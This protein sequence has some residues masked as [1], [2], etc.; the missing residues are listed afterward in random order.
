MTEKHRFRQISQIWT[1][2]IFMR[3][4]AV[5]SKRGVQLKG[6][7]ISNKIPSPKELAYSG[8]LFYF[9]QC[10]CGFRDFWSCFFDLKNGLHKR[11]YYVYFTNCFTNE[12]RNA[13]IYLGWAGFLSGRFSVDWGICKNQVINTLL[14]III[15]FTNVKAILDSLQKGTKYLDITRW[16]LKVHKPLEFGQKNGL[17]KP[18]RRLWI[19]IKI[20]PQINISYRQVKILG[21]CLWFNLLTVTATTLVV[22]WIERWTARRRAEINRRSSSIVGG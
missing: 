18:F 3:S 8:R 7:P 4:T 5:D 17:L 15:R 12:P 11:K 1:N 20:M 21:C 22:G 2:P 10:L 9:F 19:W 6:R 16:T 13:F 14:D